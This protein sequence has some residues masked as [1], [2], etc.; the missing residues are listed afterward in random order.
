MKY[1]NM[2]KKPI[3]ICPSMNVQM[4]NH[5][6]TEAQLNILKSWGYEVVGPIPKKMMCGEV[7]NGAM[8]EVKDIASFVISRFK[9]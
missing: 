2:L 1:E 9:A 7:G 6:I 3:I 5:P 8:A 4:W